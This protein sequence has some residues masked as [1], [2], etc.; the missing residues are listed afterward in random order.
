V[1]SRTLGLLFIGF[2]GASQVAA[3]EA[4]KEPVAAPTIATAEVEPAGVE[5]AGVAPAGVAPAKA[6]ESDEFVLA[7]VPAEQ[8]NYIHVS[9]QGKRRLT[10]LG[11]SFDNEPWQPMSEL[12]EPTFT[13][14]T[15]HPR[16]G[17]GDRSVRVRA[18][19]PESKKYILLSSKIT[20]AKEIV[21]LSKATTRLSD[22]AIPENIAAV[23]KGAA[24][25]RPLASRIGGY[26]GQ[27]LSM[28]NSY[29]ATRGLSALRYSQSLEDIAAINNQ[30]GGQHRYTG[31]T[32]QV[33]AAGSSTASGTLRQWQNSSGHNAILL[34]RNY[35]Q[36]G[37]H[38]DG[39]GWTANLR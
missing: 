32:A 13:Y 9:V 21:S 29:R 8:D 15:K 27:F 19:D 7:I 5:P 24:A 28:V 34:G 11:C 17:F 3:Q 2:I 39:R 14:R 37:I 31:G 4:S 16:Y 12:K 36:I 23:S 38:Y 25:P 35:Q 6:A 20:V 33:W 30:R 18:F 1:I 22:T 26:R 10:T